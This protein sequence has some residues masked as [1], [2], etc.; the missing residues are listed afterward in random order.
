MA[1]LFAAHEEAGNR[2]KRNLQIP[3]FSIRESLNTEYT[4][5]NVF[6]RGNQIE[7]GEK[8]MPPANPFAARPLG[9]SV[10]RDFLRSVRDVD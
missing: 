9:P 3:T 10:L 6:Y 2:R 1:C 7:S 8:T 4:R 5:L